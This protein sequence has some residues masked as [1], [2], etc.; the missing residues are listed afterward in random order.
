M[1]KRKLH[2]YLFRH[3]K[4]TYNT[5][6]IFSGWKDAKLTAEGI[7]NSKTI[8]KK[9]KNKKFQVAIQTRL[10]RSKDTLKYVLKDHPEC[11]TILED[12]RMIERSYGILEGMSHKAFIEKM[13]DLQFD[14]KVYGDAIENLDPKLR[15][16]IEN[17]LGVQEY[18]NQY[19]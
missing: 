13:G 1:K 18:D 6:G 8:A 19:H 15:D 14:F 9:L 4:T 17:L 3:G 11:K 5:K 10:S 12:D 16:K 2:I 7:R